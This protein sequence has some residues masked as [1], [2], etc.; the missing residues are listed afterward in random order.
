MYIVQVWLEVK[1]ERAGEFITHSMILGN[2]SKQE[3]GCMRYEIM[4]D[5]AMPNRFVFLEIFD[6]E[7]AFRAHA[8]APHFEDWKTAT[9]DMISASSSANLEALFPSP[10]SWK[11]A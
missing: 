3:G 4:R 8:E 5:M 10:N 2:Q 7:S 11:R 6:D 1:P 9:H